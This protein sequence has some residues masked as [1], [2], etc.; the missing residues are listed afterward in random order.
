[1]TYL[2]QLHAQIGGGLSFEEWV[3]KLRQAALLYG[4]SSQGKAKVSQPALPPK[5]TY[6][7][8]VTGYRRVNQ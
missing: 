8:G 2:R 6:Y 1:M 7:G 4:T 5:V 3:D